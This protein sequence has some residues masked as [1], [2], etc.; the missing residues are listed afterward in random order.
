MAFD[1]DE[2]YILETENK[3]SGRLPDT[4]KKEMMQNNGGTVYLD[5]EDWELFPIADTSDKKR[6]AR[7]ANHIIYETNQANKWLKF[8][9][10]ALAIASDGYGNLLI[11]KKENDKY[12][13]E[14]YLWNH[15]TGDLEQVANDFNELEIE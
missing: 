15:E 6:I 4:Y 11:F 9:E 14:I 3:L 2:K 10:D 1:L 12:S 13:N 5:D 8:P 7:S